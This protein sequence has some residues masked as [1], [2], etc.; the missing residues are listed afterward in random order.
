MT[1][2]FDNI[3]SHTSKYYH[4]YNPTKL[5]EVLVI[6]SDSETIKTVGIYN[7]TGDNN[8]PILIHVELTC[9]PTRIIKVET[10]AY[11][12]DMRYINHASGIPTRKAKSILQ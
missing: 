10:I 6:P 4:Q 9:T 12:L 7:E 5:K 3:I 1:T 2:Q 8:E 11:T